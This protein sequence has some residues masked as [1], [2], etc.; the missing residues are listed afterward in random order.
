[1]NSATI[2]LDVGVIY[3]GECHFMTP[4]VTS[5]ADSAPGVSM[6]LILVDNASA[7]GVENWS[8]SCPQTKVVA[9][10]RPRSYAANLNRVLDVSEAR[11]VLLL[12]T[13]MYFD[14]YEQCLTKMVKFMD[15]H[16]RAGV[17]ICRVYL[18]DGTYGEPARRFPTMGAIAARRLGMKRLFARSLAEYFYADRDR[19]SSFACDWIS[20]CFM[21]VRRDA[22]RE[23]GR[24]DEGYM[25]YF[26]DVDMCLRMGRAG[27]QV[28]FNGQTHCYHHEQRASRRA[29]S[30]DAWW[31][32]RAYLRWLYKWGLTVPRTAPSDATG[33]PWP[34]S[35]A[36]PS[37]RDR[38]HSAPARR[39]IGALPAGDQASRRSD[40][41]RQK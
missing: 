10:A 33:M 35:G 3:S 38:G 17:S 28:M 12:N 11:Y 16:P 18:P 30:R 21:L 37:R 36:T 40:V 34:T 27:W 25:K 41:S 29:L 20:G 22:M 8:Q 26:E 24:F 5:L 13:D 2:D 32:G 6:R 4:L 9:N 1:M 31:H 14:P 19:Q 23:V 15:E 39:A 7:D